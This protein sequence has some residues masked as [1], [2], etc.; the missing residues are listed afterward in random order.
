MHAMIRG[1]GRD[2]SLHSNAPAI[3]LV[4][5]MGH[6]EVTLPIASLS[7]HTFRHSFAVNLLLQGRGIRVV[8]SLLGHADLASTEVYLKVLSGETHHLLYG[9][10]F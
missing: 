10:Q 2:T 7:A 4:A 9:M 8:Q 1:A 5:S 3:D 6:G